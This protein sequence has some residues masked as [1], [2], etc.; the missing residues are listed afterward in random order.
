MISVFYT[1]LFIFPPFV[2]RLFYKIILGSLGQSCL[3]DTSVYFRYPWKVH[4]GNNVAINKD[5][6][7]FPSILSPDGKVTIGNDVSIAPGVLI[8]AASHDYSSTA[9]EDIS[10]PVLI[11]DHVWI[12]ARAI[13]FPGV[14]VGKYAV[15]GAGAV[16]TKDV[17]EYSV[18]AGVPAK[19]I[20]RR[21]LKSS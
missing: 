5:V 2:K 9:L 11:E 4:I 17:P 13:I 21:V 19:I 7:I 8:M 16:V 10:A 18:V 6:Q 20:N 15:I 1:V 12:G 14:T 3:I